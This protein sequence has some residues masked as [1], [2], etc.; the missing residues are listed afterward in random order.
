MRLACISSRGLNIHDGFRF[1]LKETRSSSLKGEGNERCAR[2]IHGGDGVDYLTWLKGPA[3]GHLSCID[4]ERMIRPLHSRFE[5]RQ[6]PEPFIFRTPDGCGEV[7]VRKQSGAN[8]GTAGRRL[9]F[10]AWRNGEKAGDSVMLDLSLDGPTIGVCAADGQ[11]ESWVA[12]AVYNT[13]AKLWLLRAAAVP[14]RGC[15][16]RQPINLA[17]LEYRPRDLRILVAGGGP[18]LAWSAPDSGSVFFANLYS[19]PSGRLAGQALYWDWSVLPSG[20]VVFA[21]SRPDFTAPG[22]R[23]LA[24]AVFESGQKPEQL[25]KTR[26]SRPGMMSTPPRLAVS[27]AGAAQ[28][29]WLENGQEATLFRKLLAVETTEQVPV[30]DGVSRLFSP[31]LL[32]GNLLLPFLTSNSAGHEVWQISLG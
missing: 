30:P 8:G 15:P 18:H 28:I 17:A 1:S 13:E 32:S 5:I 2:L 6:N 21:M 9:V 20:Q 3:W 19:S 22:G 23:S 25:D 29:C 12:W 27:G 7:F 4:D 31:L 24:T 14:H 11:E 10:Q 16:S 26:M